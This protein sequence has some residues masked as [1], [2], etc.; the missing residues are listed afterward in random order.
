MKNW[1]FGQINQQECHIDRQKKSFRKKRVI[2]PAIGMQD[3]VENAAD[4]E[5]IQTVEKAHS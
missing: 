2:Q 1:L 3:D 5:L 4:A